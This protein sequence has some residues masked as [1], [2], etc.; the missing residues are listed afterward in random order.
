MILKLS[1]KRA[2]QIYQNSFCIKKVTQNLPTKLIDNS[3]LESEN[4][5]YLRT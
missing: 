2:I 4:F 1:V 3:E 5:T